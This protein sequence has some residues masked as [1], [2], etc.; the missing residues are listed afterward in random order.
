MTKSITHIISVLLIICS[1]ALLSNGCEKEKVK[2]EV[3]EDFTGDS[4]TFIDSL[5][6]QLI[7]SREISDKNI[8]PQAES[9]DKEK[10]N[11]KVTEDFTVESQNW[12]YETLR[13]KLLEAELDKQIKQVKRFE[14]TDTKIAQ[15]RRTEET[16]STI[17]DSVTDISP[18]LY[19]LEKEI[20]K[21][22][23]EADKSVAELIFAYLKPEDFAF[24]LNRDLFET[25]KEEFEND[26]EKG[27][28]TTSGLI[29]VLTD[30]RKEAY[31]RE[32]TFEKYA[33]SSS[34]EDRFPSITAEMTLMKFAKDTIMKFVIERIEKEIQSNRREI[35][36]TDDD[37][38]LVEI[39]KSNNDLEKEKRRIRE[40]LSR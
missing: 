13:E 34:W 11:T 32:M 29:S 8:L 1:I 2:E 20:L 14:K 25:V 5:A 33:V 21:L 22:L 40:E 19:N 38:K 28:F 24:E 4:G 9:D 3:V 6:E 23:F 12:Q 10:L 17:I 16:A 36:L 15:S 18:S 30:E 39:M 26:E 27:G 7:A 35:E 31:V 37:S